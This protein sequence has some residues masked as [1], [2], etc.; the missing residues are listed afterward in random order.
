M[1]SEE[2]GD[3]DENADSREVN[4]M[5]LLCSLRIRN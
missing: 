2:G 1:G 4:K 3:V 5:V